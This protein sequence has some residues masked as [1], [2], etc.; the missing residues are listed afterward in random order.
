[1]AGP[2]EIANALVFS[3]RDRQHPGELIVTISQW[4]GL[5][6]II[7]LVAFIGFAFRQGDKTKP[8]DNPQSRNDYT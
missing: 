6:A 3:P 5:G 4:L 2:G 8:T 1:V 7:L